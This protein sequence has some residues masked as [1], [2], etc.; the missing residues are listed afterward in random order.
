[1]EQIVVMAFSWYCIPGQTPVDI[2][3]SWA[4]PRVYDIVKTKWDSLPP[5]PDKKKGGK[6]A[7]KPAAKKRP[8]SG[9]SG[10]GK[11][12]SMTAWGLQAYS[13]TSKEH[14]L[15]LVLVYL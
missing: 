9:P 8:Q 3:A 4:D 12:R 7:K 14:W 15:A 5:P 6:G 11:V 13:I 2:A 10:D 1:M